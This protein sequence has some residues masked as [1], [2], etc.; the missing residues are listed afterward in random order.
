[1]SDDAP[2]TG[3]DATEAETS[4]E[5]A[6]PTIEE[7]QAEIDKWK[8]TSRKHEDRAKANT[9]A[10]KELE[11]VKAA[12]MT[13]QERAVAEAR[14]ATRAEVLAEVANDRVEDALRLAAAGTTL[15]VDALLEGLDR[16]RFVTEDG[17]VDTDRVK[18]YIEGIAPPK[19]TDDPLVP[20]DLGQG[21]RSATPAL[22]S[23][24]LLQALKNT[25]GAR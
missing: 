25:V 17:Q 15:D 1:M 13:E 23:D 4:V 10:A 21:A 18:S 22:G 24:P 11:Q 3:T 2:D 20:V 14:A 9:A 16:A 7:L 12:S 19:P 8:A 5:G 6:T